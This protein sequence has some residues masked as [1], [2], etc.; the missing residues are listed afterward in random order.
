MPGYTNSIAASNEARPSAQQ[1]AQTLVRT[2]TA[3]F[4]FGDDL[5]NN[6]AITLT[7]RRVQHVC[8]AAPD[9]AQG[10]LQRPF[11]AVLRGPYMVP[12]V[13]LRPAA[14]KASALNPKICAFKILLLDLDRLSEMKV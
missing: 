9:S 13:E 3:F 12:K 6:T 2:R 7:S 8:W 10:F 5:V 1:S 4:R 11:L 14:F